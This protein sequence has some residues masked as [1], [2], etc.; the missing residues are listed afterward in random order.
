MIL[1]KKVHLIEAL[2]DI[3]INENSVSFLTPEYQEI[4]ENAEKYKEEYKRSPSH[5]E[6]LYG[7]AKFTITFI[8]INLININFI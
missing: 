6:R 8:Q 4:L 7:M 5:L 2:K 1:A 3:S